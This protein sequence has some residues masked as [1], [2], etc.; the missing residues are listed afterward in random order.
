MQKAIRILSSTVKVSLIIADT[1]F[2]ESYTLFRVRKG[3]SLPLM[4]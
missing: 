2:E 4:L 3:T 1:V